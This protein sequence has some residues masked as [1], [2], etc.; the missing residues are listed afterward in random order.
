MERKVLIKKLESELRQ[1]RKDFED[2][3][4]I[5]LEKFDWGLPMHVAESNIDHDKKPIHKTD[6]LLSSSFSI[7]ILSKF[8]SLNE[9]LPLDSWTVGWRLRIE[10][11]LNHN[12]NK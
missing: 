2:G 7:S 5:P 12:V 3:K 11:S 1:A 8:S 6:W 9:K 4:F 10:L